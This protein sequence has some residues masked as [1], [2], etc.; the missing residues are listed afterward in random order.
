VAMVNYAPEMYGD[1]IAAAYDDIE[2]RGLDTDGAVSMLAELAGG[3]LSLELGIGTGRIAV[4]LAARGVSVH[5]V[6]ISDA[7]IRRLRERPGGDS[8]P[9]IRGDLADV[10]VESSY[11]LIYIVFNTIFFLQTQED[12]VRCFGNAAKHLGDNGLFVVEASDMIGVAAH[13]QVRMSMLEADRVQF[14]AVQHDPVEQRFDVQRVVVTES[15]IQLYPVRLRYAWPSELDLMAR[16]AGLRLRQ[17]WGGWRGEP[18]KS[19]GSLHVS[20]YERL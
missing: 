15:G 17:R 5:G 9:V 13:G 8:I 19:E 18:F 6:E 11:R 14:D 12:Q 7:M 2:T 10:P 1:Q 20:I 3:G 16:L 4:P